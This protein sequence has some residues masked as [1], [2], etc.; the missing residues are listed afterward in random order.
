MSARGSHDAASRAE[1]KF[2]EQGLK[3]S[4]N[5]LHLMHTNCSDAHI[6]VEQQK[7]VL[8]AL[9]NTKG[10]NQA[11][12]E[13][14]DKFQP[15]QLLEANSIGADGEYE[16]GFAEN[17]V[18]QKTIE[19]SILLTNLF[20]VLNRFQDQEVDVGQSPPPPTAWEKELDMSPRSR[21]KAREQNYALDDSQTLWE[22]LKALCLDILS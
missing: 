19:R 10:V 4:T 8:Q 3:N 18:E 5:M 6:V 20:K 17:L 1:I 15:I 12:R 22:Q 7:L 16:V 11:I 13:F 14:K 21:Q 9:M 2:L